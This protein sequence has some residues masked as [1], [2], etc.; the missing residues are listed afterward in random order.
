MNK[1]VLNKVFNK[2][3]LLEEDRKYLNKII[4][5]IIDNP[6]F[7]KRMTNEFLHHSDVTLGEHILE[8]TILTYILSKKYLSEKKSNNYRIDLAIKIALFHDL[9]TIPWQNNKNARVHHFFSKHGFRHPIEAVINAITWYPDIFEKQDEAIV[10]I[11]GILHH[12][13][14]LPVRVVNIKKINKVE[15]KNIDDFNSLSLLYKEMIINNLKRGKLGILSF[16]KSKY[17]EGRIMAKADRIVSRGQIKN[18]SSLIALITGY[19]KKL[20]KKNK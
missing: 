19:N 10:I 12:M 5:P 18:M 11:D 4:F 13:Y 17:I 15:L 14:P 7:K 20:N 16:K 2:Y 9:Y 8:D 1:I 3:S 6:N